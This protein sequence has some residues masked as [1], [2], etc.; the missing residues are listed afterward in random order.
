MC[1]LYDIGRT[2]H[3]SR[4]EWGQAV[5]GVIR[6]LE[7]PFGIRR[8]DAGVVASLQDG[9]PV[10]ETMRWGFERPYNAAVN[11]AR[12]EKLNGTW[13]KLWREKR[14]CLIPVSTFYEWSGPAGNKQTFAFENRDDDLGL[15]I[16]GI[17]EEGEA[18][19]SF[20]MLTSAANEQIQ[21]IHDR[22]PAL[23]AAEQF[24]EFLEGEDPVGLLG[25]W[26]DPLSILRCENPLKHLKAH[27]G[28]VPIDF[29]P[30]LGDE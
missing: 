9:E 28:P 7:K 17:W 26:S 27:T 1:N 30:G 10:A 16:A 13:S 11:N 20:S 2:R 14:R 22:M 3:Q 15:W 21:T 23:L 24:L 18:G 5:A 4:D 19:R 12:S 29:L 25:T 8:T 6:D